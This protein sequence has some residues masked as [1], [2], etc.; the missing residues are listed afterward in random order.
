MPRPPEISLPVF[1]LVLSLLLAGLVL[2]LVAPRLGLP[3]PVL[4][5]LGGAALALVP[6]MP[7]VRLDPELALALFVAPILL[8]AAYDTSPRDMRANWAPLA[9]M[10]LGLVVVTTLAVA[11]VAHALDPRLPW[12]AAFAL[13]AIVAPPDAVAATSV[14]R[15]TRLPR[16]VLVIL[17]GESLLN[18]APALLAYRLA[19]DLA[20]GRSLAGWALPLALGQA[21]GGVALGWVLARG[22]V[23]LTRAV[24]PGPAAIV[25]QF[26]GTFGVWLLADRL[27]LS[28]V[29]T[30][31]AYAMVIARRADREAPARARRAAYAVWEVAVFTLTLLAFVLI[32]LQ[33]RGI[34]G[35]LGERA[36]AG[37]GFAAGVVAATVLVRLAWVFAC[38][39]GAR[40]ARRWSPALRPA[41]SGRGALAIGWCGMRGIVTLA[42]AL[43]LP[44]EFPARDLLVFAAFCVVLAT[45][46]VQG[47][48]LRPL[49][50]G[51]ALA[52]DTGAEREVALASRE[53]AQAALDALGADRRSE[54]GRLLAREYA[55]R[56]PGTPDAEDPTGRY[57]LRRRAI[58]AERA[59]L[60][61]LR[62]EGRIGEATFQRIEEDLDWA[63]AEGEG[64][65][66]QPPGP[67]GPA[68]P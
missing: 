58:A 33:L 59:R 7:D 54:P 30:V 52:R 26:L 39:L 13:G 35:R 41:V 32:G 3:W 12:A 28:P 31:V 67:R 1:E 56:L 61:A 4:V 50:H 11:F 10:V 42:T 47:L 46:V 63:E 29:L 40:V 21:V 53:L 57:A 55:A 36:W 15:T 8:D 25:L 49:L 66:I 44:L 18:D 27:A 17:Q 16:R 43:A 5:A 62:A 60:A 38:H 2:A 22:F 14:L 20:S 34:L 9:S 23:L 19:V 51:S 6:G 24:E 48:T 64:A 37:L 65:G 45:L 68:T